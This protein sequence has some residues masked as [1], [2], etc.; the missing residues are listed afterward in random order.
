MVVLLLPGAVTPIRDLQAS[1]YLPPQT[2]NI[3]ILESL[4]LDDLQ[5]RTY[6][7]KRHLR[8]FGLYKENNIDIR[9]FNAETDRDRAHELLKEAIAEQRPDL[10]VTIAT[11][12]SQVGRDILKDSNI[13]QLFL[14]VASPVQAGLITHIEEPSG[15][16]ITGVTRSIDVDRTTNFVKHVAT[17]LPFKNPLRIGVLHSNYPASV[18]GFHKLKELE[19]ER[20][21]IRFVPLPII[22][23]DT[24]SKMDSIVKAALEIIENNVDEIDIIWLSEGPLPRKEEYVRPLIEKSVV[25]IVFTASPKGSEWGVWCSI[26]SGA[27]QEGHQA[28][29]MANAI[30]HGSSAGSIPVMRGM[31]RS[32]KVNRKAASRWGYEIPPMGH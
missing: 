18:G 1:D 19:I 10:V 27:D 4:K 5:A 12:A 24:K 29:L 15:S 13:P 14:F 7:F 21:D 11:L 31:E 26:E 16:N 8:Q 30:L 2:L 22:F 23:R 9:V 32:Y 6:S 20:K 25:P 28:A 17:N 3:I